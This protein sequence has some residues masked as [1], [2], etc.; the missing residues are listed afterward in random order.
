LTYR[1]AVARIE[2]E[3][4]GE[5]ATMLKSRMIGAHRPPPPWRETLARIRQ[6]QVT[7][8][9]QNQKRR[10]EAMLHWHDP[11]ETL[12]TLRHRSHT[13]FDENPASG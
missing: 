11:V 12:R 4:L 3:R 7:E 2:A 5:E 8:I 13:L 6:V 1:N 9:E 10:L